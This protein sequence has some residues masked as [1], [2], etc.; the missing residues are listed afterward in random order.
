[1]HLVL[2]AN[3]LIWHWNM[4][5]IKTK[6]AYKVTSKDLVKYREM[7]LFPQK[8]TDPGYSVSDMT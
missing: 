7:D 4:T 8:L 1:M 6:I 3:I 2:A 5:V